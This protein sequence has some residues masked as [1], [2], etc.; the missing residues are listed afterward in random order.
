V[1]DKLNITICVY[2]LLSWNPA[3]GAAVFGRH[4]YAAGRGTAAL[5]KRVCGNVNALRA[6]RASGMGRLAWL[7][8]LFGM[9]KRL[10]LC[11]KTTR[12][13]NSLYIS[14]LWRWFKPFI[15]CVRMACTM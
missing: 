4:F 6:W 7:F 15:W 8:G 5:G 14:S 12:F 9:M 3:F 2:G 10:V 11:G 13:Y 1:H